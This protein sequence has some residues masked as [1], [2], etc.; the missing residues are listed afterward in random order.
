MLS[1]AKNFLLEIIFPIRCV[2]CG[3]EGDWFCENCA[4]K[5]QLN[6][7]QFCPVCWQAN[8]GGRICERCASPLDGLRVAASYQKNPELAHAIQALKYKFS[9][10]LAANLAAVLARSIRSK[11]YQ[12][13]R[14]II[15]IPLHKKRLRWRGFNQA[16]LLA[17]FV[18]QELNLPL[19]RGLIRI[20]NTPQQAKL[21]RN[22]RIQNLANAFALAPDFSPLGKTILLVDDVASTGTTLVEAA[23]ILKQNGAREVWGLVLARG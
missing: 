4:R 12:A 1:R 7:Q 18:S 16:E 8:L 9:E 6:P 22:E 5:V 11:N 10:P 3:E 23:K 20:K 14:I 15:S 2:G 19:E 13:E 17:R 21:S